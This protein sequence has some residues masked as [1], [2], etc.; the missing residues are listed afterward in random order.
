MGSWTCTKSRGPA[1][2][3]NDAGVQDPVLDELEV[4]WK[5]GFEDAF[6]GFDDAQGFCYGSPGSY[7][8]VTSPVHSGKR[9]AAFT[10]NISDGGGGTQARC[11]R[12]GTFPDDAYYT[13]W[14]YLP[15]LPQTVD[16]WN[17][18]H[19]QGGNGDPNRWP[20]L[21]DATLVKSA[22]GGFGLKLVEGFN[23]PALPAQD[24]AD[25]PVG[26]WFQVVMRFHRSTGSGGEVTLYQGDTLL[27]D[28]KGVTDPYPYDQWYVG[29]LVS[30]T[31]EP[32]LTVYV[33]DVSISST[34]P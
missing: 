7:K 9:A 2:P 25:I 22:D 20:S 30:S 23:G 11:V 32:D 24:P 28:V 31:T 27:A 34:K 14:F 6:C 19:F 5:T 1:G 26:S 4:P 10:V 29:N 33:D 8:S 17:L 13:A 12:E 21:W 3:V 16:N 15:S 18:L